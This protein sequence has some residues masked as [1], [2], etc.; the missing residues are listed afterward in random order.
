[1]NE[2]DKYLSEKWDWYEGESDLFGLTSGGFNG[3]SDLKISD[4]DK[5]QLDWASS[6]AQACGEPIQTI[7]KK[8]SSYGLK[9]I[10]EKWAKKVS[11]GEVN[12]ISNGHLIL[13]MIDAGFR[14]Q[15]IENTPNVYFNVSERAI[16][17][18]IK[19]NNQ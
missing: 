7:N 15:R 2:I 10:A 17:W 12:Y 16:K 1:M 4:F 11:C 18:L 5:E 3:N 8:H 9:H 19:H 13:A 14:F 6:F